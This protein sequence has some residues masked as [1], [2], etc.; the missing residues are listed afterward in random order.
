MSRGYRVRRGGQGANW[1]LSVLLAV[2]VVLVN[3]PII[4]MIFNSFKS[5]DEILSGNNLLPRALSL[6]NYRYLTERTP[7][8]T[9]FGNSFAVALGGTALSIVAASL[10]GFSLS[11]P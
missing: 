8:W 7:F 5:T 9:Y 6:A 1:A 11:R 4:S 2:I 10:A 3:L